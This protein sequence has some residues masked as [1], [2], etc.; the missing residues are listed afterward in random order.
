MALAGLAAVAG[1][2]T[3]SAPRSGLVTGTLPLCYG[4]GPNMNLAPTATIE[5]YRS[6]RLVS[7][8]TFPASDE[9]RTYTLTLPA[10]SYELRMSGRN[11][12]LKVQV[13]G[14]SKTRA[15]WPQPGCV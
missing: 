9:H 8:T 5:A 4:P 12:T 15:D 11:Y 2:C 3:H 13:R 1:A 7:K 6:G 10:G 14:A